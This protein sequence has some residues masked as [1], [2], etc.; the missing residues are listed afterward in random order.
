[1]KN[2]MM[3]GI[4][5]MPVLLLPRASRADELVVTDAGDPCGQVEAGTLRAAILEANA[6]PGQDTIV[7]AQ[8]LGGSVTELCDCLPAIRDEIEIVAEGLDDDVVIDARRLRGCHVLDFAAPGASHFLSGQLV[9]SGGWAANHAIRV[10]PRQSLRAE[11]SRIEAHLAP[12]AEGAVVVDGELKLGRT[13]FVQN[14]ANMG[15]AI[16]VRDTGSL[17]V[18]ECAFEE[19]GAERGG[20]VHL[21]GERAV[22]ERS[23]FV[24]NAAD[25]GGAILVERGT[26]SMVN[27]TLS[28]NLAAEGGAL[29]ARTGA[30]EIADST[31][32]FNQGHSGAA[33]LHVLDGEVRVA[34]SILAAQDGKACRI[35]GGGS[36]EGAPNIDA[37]GTCGL[38]GV[39]REVEL[40]PLADHGGFTATHAILPDDWA[41]DTGGTTCSAVDQRG[42]PRPSGARCDLGA[43]EHQGSAGSQTFTVTSSADVCG[44]PPPGTLRAAILEANAHPGPDRIVWDRRLHGQIVVLCGALPTI[45]ESVAILAEGLEG[46]AAIDARA[47]GGAAIFDLGGAPGSTHVLRG[48]LLLRGGGANATALRVRAGQT[49]DARL[50]GIEGFVNEGDHGAVR[51]EGHLRLER[52]HLAGNR[53]GLGAAISVVEGGVLTLVDALF[54][55][56]VGE[57]GGAIHADASK[58]RVE[59]T[60]FAHNHAEAGGAL[61]IAGS[62]VSIEN[63]TFSGNTAAAGGAILADRSELGLVHTTLAFNQAEWGAD[64]LHLMDAFAWV[65]GSLLAEHDGSPCILDGEAEI[66]GTSNLDEDGACNVGG[67]QDHVD[68]RPLE[69]DGGYSPTH[70]IEWGSIAHDASDPDGCPSVDQRGLPRPAG[71]ACDLGAYEVQSE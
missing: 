33:A 57:L 41:F 30:V 70:A 32:A 49:V 17:H 34:G 47:A 9:L 24:G 14:K 51:V 28:A 5:L 63:T 58:V 43:Y 11:V 13:R 27:S 52:T 67:I 61:F 59:R 6:R 69:W 39:Q 68:L 20:A 50:V 71:D 19:N 48:D 54:E 15:A 10:G 53:A 22:I 37:D 18:L 16:T 2:S 12:D 62:E 60:L 40:L 26:L 3:V 1:M 25:V 31:I 56:N 64:A 36:I 65:Q 21:G 46:P 35:E 7:F 45:T 4:C 66:E 29:Y 38:E 55:E 42:L 44:K 23:L 8:H